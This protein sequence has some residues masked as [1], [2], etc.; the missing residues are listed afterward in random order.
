MLLCGTYRHQSGHSEIE[1]DSNSKPEDRK[2]TKKKLTVS[3]KCDPAMQ[4]TSPPFCTSAL[5]LHQCCSARLTR[6]G[7]ATESRLTGRKTSEVPGM[8]ILENDSRDERILPCAQNSINW[9]ECPRARVAGADCP[10]VRLPETPYSYSVGSHASSLRSSAI[11][12]F[13]GGEAKTD[14]VRFVRKV[15]Q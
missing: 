4:T 15:I 9:L 14:N 6:A 7:L 11:S 10:T 13:R 1:L 5:V 2:R 8:E 3:P 12:H